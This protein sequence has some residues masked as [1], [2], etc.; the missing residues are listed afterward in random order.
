M[1]VP[2]SPTPEI[3]I[4]ALDKV[5]GTAKYAADISRPGMLWAKV[6]RSPLPHARIVSIDTSRARALPGVHVVLT[7]HDL[8]PYRVGRSMRDMPILARDKV[9]FV[10]EKVA[11]VAAEDLDTAE[12]A[13]SLI[14][15]EYEELP[16][17]FDPVEA[18]KPGAPLIHDP[19]EVRAWATPRQVVADYPNSVSNPVWGASLEEVERAFAQ[20]AH[21]FEHTFRTPVQHQGYLEPHACLVEFDDRGVAHVWA[22]NKAPFLLLNYLE[23][24]LELK[25]G[26]IEVHMLPVGGCFGG[27]GSFMDVPVVYF[28][29]K[30]SGRP[31]K[32][33][34][35]YTEELMAANPRHAAVI[36]VKSGFSA[37]GRLLAR[38]TRAVYAS[39]AYAAFKPQPNATLPGIRGGGLGPYPVPV[40]R[41]EGHM[42]YTNTVPGGHMRAPGEAQPIHATECHMDLCA[43]AMGMDPLHLRLINAP[44]DPRETP[45]GEPGSPRRARQV[46]QEAARAIGWGQP[47]PPGV[48][49]GIALAEVENSLG[50]YTAEMVVER[51]GLYLP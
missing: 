37:D 48:G 45:S 7:G 3:R 41:V 14:D 31:V 10:G 5:T 27:K 39:G 19:Q 13:I 44:S 24:G 4:D 30:L 11:A 32:M 16:A 46:L 43:R 9:R 35:T 22:S 51:S 6:L 50:I 1:T 34:M 18:M 23:A 21:V 25:R 47:K 33:V 20:C 28:L 40:W 17:V 42:V 8:P 12:E 38:Y 29:A 49:R 15:V 26:D 36:T 2:L